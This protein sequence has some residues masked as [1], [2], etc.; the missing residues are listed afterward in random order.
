MCECWVGLGWAPKGIF[1]RNG[2]NTAV[3]GAVPVVFIPSEFSQHENVSFGSRF[4][5]H[6]LSMI[7]TV[8]F[9]ATVCLLGNVE[10]LGFWDGTIGKDPRFQATRPG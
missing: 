6:V 1:P 9:N 8:V 3:L 10:G 5:E 2:A 4:C 7:L